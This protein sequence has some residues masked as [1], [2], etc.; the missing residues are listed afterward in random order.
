MDGNVDLGELVAVVPLELVSDEVV[1]TEDES[2]TCASK[3]QDCAT[4]LDNDNDN[5]NDNG[6]AHDSEQEIPISCLRLRQKLMSA[7]IV[8]G[9]DRVL[10]TTHDASTITV[11]Q[12]QS[13]CST[14]TPPSGTVGSLQAPASPL[15][16]L[17]QPDESQ[18]TVA[19]LND[20]VG[21]TRM[22]LLTMP[23]VLIVLLQLEALQHKADLDCE[24]L[25]L[26]NAHQAQQ[27]AD[28]H[29]CGPARLG[30]SIVS[31]TS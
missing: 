29:V 14:S 26:V 6:R 20:K 22:P 7:N 23:L 15:L 5:D 16:H 1:H 11:P 24:A 8:V 17:Q 27:L 18:Q 13:L 10:P 9:G 28:L 4:S 19:L 31:T 12:H 3:T 21:A 25:Q 30:N 2:A